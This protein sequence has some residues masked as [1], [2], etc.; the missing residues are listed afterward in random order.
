MPK[1]S[2]LRMSDSGKNHR[3]GIAQLSGDLAEKTKDRVMA[4]TS[5]R[6]NDRKPMEKIRLMYQ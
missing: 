4:V 2:K 5:T 3:D 6:A 1:S